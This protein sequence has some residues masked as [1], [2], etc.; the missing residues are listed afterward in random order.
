MVDRLLTK[1][2]LETLGAVGGVEQVGRR[3]HERG[4]KLCVAAV[5][6]E[7][8][9]LAALVEHPELGVVVEAGLRLDD[10]RLAGDLSVGEKRPKAGRVEAHGWGNFTVSRRGRA[11]VASL[12]MSLT[13]ASLFSGGGGWDAG[14]VDLGLRPVF[15]VEIDPKIAAWHHEVFGGRVLASDIARVDWSKAP[16]HVDVLV[17]SPPCQATSLSGKGRASLRAA[18]GIEQSSNPAY[19]DPK[20]GIHTL[21]AVDAMSPNVVLLENNEGYQGSPTFEAIVAGLAA[22][23]YAVDYDVVDAADYGVPSSRQ[24]LILRASRASA[25]LPPW[26][27]RKP[28][29]DWLSAVDDLI[30]E[31]PLDALA[32][33]QKKALGKVPAPSKPFLVAGGNPTRTPNGYRVWRVA[34]QPAWA[35]QRAQNTSGMR[36]VDRAGQ[37][38]RITVRGIARLQG[39]SDRYPVDEG[40]RAFMVNMIGNSVPPSLAY[41]M[42]EPFVG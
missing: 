5:T 10:G 14:A 41:A 32:L 40:R 37:S 39:F 23:G 11:V 2:S 35:T 27:V 33:W 20:V 17:S 24:R 22:R 15:A 7:R 30:E 38:H 42:L 36:I 34:G 16:S 31:M 28:R 9:A 21:D 3:V 1:R 4:E 26:P 12:D 18:R 13:F 25:G 6:P 19:C 29:V 8:D